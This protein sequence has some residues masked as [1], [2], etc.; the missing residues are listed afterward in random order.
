MTASQKT[1]ELGQKKF[2][3]ARV[4][5]ELRK[6][7]RQSL[8]CAWERLASVKQAIAEQQAALKR[9]DRAIE[10]LEAEIKPTAT[11]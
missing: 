7:E 2:E 1:L 9:L 4:T 8:G 10:R 3:R 5:S 6:L 11:E